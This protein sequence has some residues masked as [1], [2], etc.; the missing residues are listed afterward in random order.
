MK[1]QTSGRSNR[2]E[3]AEA[4]AIVDRLLPLV[5]GAE[6]EF[7]GARGWGIVDILG[8]GLITNLIKHAKLNSA[9]QIMFQINKLLG[10][11]QRELSDIRFPT[12]YEMRMGGF[13]SF[14]DF[15]FDGILADVWMQS[16]ILSSLEQVRQLGERLR[17]LRSELDGLDARNG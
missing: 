2:E 5:D 17:T 12:D 10:D 1:S 7:R 6:A 9:R 11:L 13:S 15:V 8:G 16:R 14:A 4:R 3:I